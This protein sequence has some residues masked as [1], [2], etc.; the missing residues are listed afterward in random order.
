V[1]SAHTRGKPLR[2]LHVG[3]TLYRGGVSEATGNLCRG[4]ARLGHR[5]WLVCN[6]GEAATMAARDG[7]EVRHIP[8]DGGEVGALL[9]SVPRLRATLAQ[10]QPDVV[11]V[12]GR[13]SSLVA[14]LAGRYPDWF[15]LHSTHLTEQVGRLDHGWTRRVLSPLGRRLFVLDDRALS[16]CE[17]HLGIARHR[18]RRLPNG[19]DCERFR[20]PT[21]EERHRARGVFEVDDGDT[22]VVYVGRFRAEKQPEAVVALARAVVRTGRQGVRVAMVGEGA[23]EDALRGTIRHEGLGH[24]CR[25][26]PWMDARTPYHAADLVVMPSRFEGY[27]LAAA[28]AMASGCPLLRSRTGGFE[29]MVREG[30]TGF[31][32]DPDPEDFVRVA[33]DLLA[34][35]TR[36]QAVRGPAAEHA[37]AQL[38][39]ARQASRAVEAYREAM[40]RAADP[41]SVGAAQCS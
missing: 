29:A 10:A 27:G 7:V 31:G 39:L 16:Y 30:V 22:L 34:D 19:V 5:V 12:H 35:G 33:L 28:E 6:G 3:S 15:T 32:C 21:P 40:A 13:A 4:Q 20:P 17:E 14:L 26:Y 23:M 36:L 9:R 24:L 2:I 8:F 1:S 38:S 11:H 41:D 37:R 18:I 25:M